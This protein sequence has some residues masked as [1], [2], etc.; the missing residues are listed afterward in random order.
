MGERTEAYDELYEENTGECGGKNR[1][2]Y[3]NSRIRHVYAVQKSRKFRTRKIA[4]AF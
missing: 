2:H 1:M 3:H 4:V